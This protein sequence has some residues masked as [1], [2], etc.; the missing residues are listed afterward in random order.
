MFNLSTG[1]SELVIRAV[2]VYLFLFVVF[3]F[4]GKR[5]LGNSPHSI[6]L[7]C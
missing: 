6:C 1:A 3:K 4:I 2:I 5:Q 7:S